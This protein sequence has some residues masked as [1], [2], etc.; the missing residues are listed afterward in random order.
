MHALGQNGGWPLSMFLTADA[1]PFHGETYLPPDEKKVEG[2]TIRGFK[3]LLKL[4]H[5]IY[6]EKPKELQEHADKV[7]QATADALALE[8]GIALVKLDRELVT[9]GVEEVKESYDKEY[10]GFGSPKRKFKGPRFP[11]PSHLELLLHEG[12]RTKSDELLGMVTNTL[13]HMAQGGIYDQLGGGFHR[14][15]TERTWTVPHFEKMLYDNA[16]LVELYARAF[17]ATKKPLY[18]RVVEETLAFIKREMTDKGGAFYSSLDA[19]TEGEE[20]RSYVWTDKEIDDVLTDKA[21]AKLFRE[22]YGAAG[23]PNF[24]GKYHILFLPK[25]IAEAAKERKLSEEELLAR[26]APLKKKLFEARAKRPQPFL[27][28]TVLTAWNGQMI[29]GY[30]VAGWCLKEPRYVESAARAAEFVLKH[31]RNDKG[32]LLRTYAGQPGK[33]PEARVNAYLEDYAFLVHGLLALYDATKQKKWLDEARALTDTMVQY[34]GEKN[35]GGFYFTSNDHEKL[36]ARAKDQY[37]GAQPSGNSLA[38]RNL[39]RLWRATGEER[40]RAEAEKSFRHF[41]GTLKVAPSSLTALVTT[42]SMYLDGKE[43][44]AEKK[45]S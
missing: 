12:I 4:V 8:R 3:D 7:A 40:Y 24:E 22:V 13:D 20:G 36:F 21:E 11:M 34:Y 30:A 42:L 16:Q 9:A 17:Q 35:K 18:R 31:L 2:G 25:P 43:A 23:K 32:R 44:R 15:S 6:T 38:A 45:K 27:T 29:A 37:D 19:E 33:T 39:V 5:K 28:R 41:A 26:L 10:G 1:K 14:Y